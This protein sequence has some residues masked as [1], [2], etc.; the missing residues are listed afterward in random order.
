MGGNACAIN[1]KTKEIIQYAYPIDL[2][3]LNRSKL[4]Q[5]IEECIKAINDAFKKRYGYYIWFKE[6]SFKSFINGS[7]KHL[8]NQRIS[9]DW[10][11]KYKKI[12]GDIDIMF[13]EEYS[14]KLFNLLKELENKQITKDIK[15]IGQ[16][17]ESCYGQINSVFNINNEFYPQ[18]DFEPVKF[19]EGEPLDFYKFSHSSDFRD[20]ELGI[21][22]VA[23]KYLLMNLVRSISDAPDIKVLQKSSGITKNTLK[24]SKSFKEKRLLAFSITNGLREKYKKVCTI[25]NIDY[26]KEL[27]TSES[28]Y[29][30]NKQEIFKKIFPDLKNYSN[31]FES[32]FGLI[33]LINESSSIND[34]IKFKI[35]ENMF[36]QLWGNS[37]Q[38]LVRNNPNEDF[39]IKMKIF[40]YLQDHL[41]LFDKDKS[42]NYILDVMQIADYYK[43]YKMVSIDE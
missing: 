22:G 10:F 37:A 20:I 14:E 27:E 30:T 36:N 33:N 13:P 17:K 26:Y 18:I 23:H 35:F 19:V 16:K 24:L 21:K 6:V 42:I 7:S 38:G 40:N 1:H 12:I 15:Y 2:T 25:D 3:L 29:I 11:L 5:I 41:Y 8:F 31:Y 32:Y 43:N 39:Q 4:V 28:N 34:D 9:D